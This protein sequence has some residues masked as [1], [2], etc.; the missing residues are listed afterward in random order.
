MSTDKEFLQEVL[1]C[2][3]LNNEDESI[4]RLESIIAIMPGYIADAVVLNKKIEG[5]ECGISKNLEIIKLKNR[6]IQELNQYIDSGEGVNVIDQ[7]LIDC[8]RSISLLKEGIQSRDNK[9]SIL[10]KKVEEL[11]DELQFKRI[12]LHE[13]NR[14]YREYFR[15]IKNNIEEPEPVETVLTVERIRDCLQERLLEEVEHTED[16]HLMSQL[17]CNLLKLSDLVKD[18]QDHNT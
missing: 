8:E 14:D 17:A 2:W 13:S 6:H 16:D 4:N 15:A 12:A 7:N 3:V 11:E 1:D 18:Y 5:L 9:I 10:E